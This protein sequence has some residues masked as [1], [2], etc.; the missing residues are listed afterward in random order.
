MQEYI[1]IFCLLSPWIHLPY[2]IISFFFKYDIAEIL[3][4]KKKISNQLGPLESARSQY[5]STRFNVAY[6]SFTALHLLMKRHL[7]ANTMI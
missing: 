4:V 5:E 7:D 2:F 6:I 1:K 3:L